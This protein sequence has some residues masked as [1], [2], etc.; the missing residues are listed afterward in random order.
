MEGLLSVLLVLTWSFPLFVALLWTSA[1]LR[2]A[3]LQLAP[4][5]ALPGLLLA[6]LAGGL[7]APP[8]VGAPMTEVTLPLLFT[9]VDLVLDGTGRSFLLFT[10]ILWLAGGLFARA[11]H[12]TD[13]RRGRFF[14]FFSL[15]LA[16]NLG[17]IVAGDMLAFYLFFALMTFAAYGLVVHA[18]S[19][20]ALRAGKVY[21]VMAIVGEV[22]LLAGLF[23][24]GGT[25]G[26]NPAFG[27]QLESTWVDL[28][29]GEGP[30]FGGAAVALL[31]ASGLGVK[32]GLIP[33][34][35]WLPLAHPVAP[36]AASALLSGAMIKAGLLG[37]MRVLPAE[38]PLPEAS[39][40]LLVTGALAA[41]YGVVAGIL[42]DDPKTVLA[43]S[44]VSQMGYMAMGTG[45]LVAHPELAPWAGVALMLYAVHHG[46]AKG[47]LFLSVGLADRVPR[48][49]GDRARWWILGGTTLP[50]LALAGLPLTSGALA[51]NTLKEGLGEMGGTTY[52]V[53]E[54]YLPLAA[55][56]T[57]LLMARFLATLWRRREAADPG[58]RAFLPF[59][60]GTGTLVAPWAAL[61]L[62]G[63]GG[64]AWLPISVDVP[65]NVALPGPG[66]EVLVGL[67]PVLVGAA[68]GW[69][70]WSRSRDPDRRGLLPEGLAGARVPAGDL[71]VPVEAVLRWLPLPNQEEWVESLE[72]RGRRGRAR[73]R[74][75]ARQLDRLAA[76]DV[77]TVN[78]TLLGVI[79]VALGAG[80]VLLL[81][82]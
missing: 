19:T 41:L 33:L 6:L 57:T 24:L 76:R 44:S 14:L 52:S 77:E 5:A 45:L 79:L 67:L 64:M 35:L 61:V 30:T 25:F 55:L 80:L 51:K 29:A 59:S 53:L 49:D 42:Q 68:V 28:A 4:F 36:T 47:A 16:G 69:V 74:L 10:S 7:P 65:A 13:V 50:A 43:Y 78:G 1:R 71:L 12:A 48:G 27:A 46:I 40:V 31:L 20:E 60:Y 3:G 37:W 38:T 39:T 11:Y 70:V 15:T 66:A 2:G 81:M 72:R 17:L 8:E 21:I 58:T 32:A 75:A 56:G 18:A 82:G 63:A 54:V 9:G 26:G 23:S 73:M 34:H 22:L 62:L